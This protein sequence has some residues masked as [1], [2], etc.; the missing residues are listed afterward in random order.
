MNHLQEDFRNH[1]LGI[2]L[3][4]SNRK[5]NHMREKPILWTIIKKK[6]SERSFP[7]IWPKD[8]F[9]PLLPPGQHPSFLSIRRMGN[10]VPAKIIGVS[11][12]KLSQTN[13]LYRSS[14]N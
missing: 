8:I 10:Y 7:K 13:I 11:T 4:I 1:D 3:L 9:A 12:N 5:P 14:P 6:H 2:T